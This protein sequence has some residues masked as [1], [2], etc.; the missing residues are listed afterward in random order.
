MKPSTAPPQRF[1][2]AAEAGAV[3]PDLGSQLIELL[4]RGGVL[5]DV[6]DW[7]EQDYEALYAL[8][9]NLYAQARYFDAM[10]AFGYLVMHNHLERRFLNAFAA[11]LQMC[12]SYDEA[13]KYYQMALMMDMSE[14]AP[15]FHACECMVALGRV[16]QAREGLGAVIA[17]AQ[18]KEQHQALAQRAQALLGLL[19]TDTAAGA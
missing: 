16:Q 1:S 10:K 17:L 13:L 4:G 15:A 8:G 19:G 9:H 14:P 2:A 7:G 6:Y 5:G 3:H 11:S 18:G 12:K